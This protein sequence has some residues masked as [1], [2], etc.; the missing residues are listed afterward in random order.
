MASQDILE[1]VADENAWT[2]LSQITL[3]CEF[4]DLHNLD[5]QLAAFLEERAEEELE[6]PF[7]DDEDDDPDSEEY[8]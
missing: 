3:L 4:I 5:E 7:D 1:H 6:N 2:K 8:D